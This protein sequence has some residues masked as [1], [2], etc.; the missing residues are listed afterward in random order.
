MTP[1]RAPAAVMVNVLGGATR[2]ARRLPHVMAPDP[3]VKVHLYGKT[4][5]PG[6]KVGHVTARATTPRTCGTAPGTP[7]TTSRV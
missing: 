2:P 4:V 3:G 7:P 6:R 5:R 1:A